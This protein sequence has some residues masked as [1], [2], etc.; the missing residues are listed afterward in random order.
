MPKE[1]FRKIMHSGMNCK[2]TAPELDA[3][4]PLFNNE[5]TI[6]GCEFMVVFYRLRY[7]HRSNLLTERI[8]TKKR[9]SESQKYQKLKQ[10]EDLEQKVQIT[11]TDNYTNEDLDSAMKKMVNASVNY[12]R[13]NVGAVQLD[14]FDC[15]YMQP[16]VFR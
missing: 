3:I 7:E 15:E 12:D 2:L 14:A 13:L 11:L 5:G 9:M 16:N 4:L 1:L 8:A 6:D 10:E